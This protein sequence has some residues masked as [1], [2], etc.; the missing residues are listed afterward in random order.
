[1]VTKKGC[2]AAAL[3]AA[4]LMAA[5]GSALAEG[6]V[7][8][9]SLT[10]PASTDTRVSVP[11]TQEAVGT[12]QLAANGSG[13]TVSLTGA[14][15]APGTEFPANSAGNPLFYARFTSGALAGRWFNIVSNGAGT[16]DLNVEDTAEAANV[17]AALAGDSLEIYP[18]WTVSALFPADF[19]GLAFTV[20]TSP[21][22]RSFEV[23]L[24]RDS[25]GVGTDV[26]AGTGLFYFGTPFNTWLNFGFTPAPDTV[27]APQ[28]TL[29]LR[30]NNPVSTG[31]PDDPG[32]LIDES[33]GDLTFIGLG[34]RG[35]FEVIENIPVLSTKNDT[36]L[37]LNNITAVT[38]DESGLDAVIGNL[39]SPTSRDELLVS[40]PP[41]A[42]AGPDVPFL[43]QFVRFN[44]NWF[45]SN[46]QPA[47]DFE[48]APGSVVV[49]RKLAGTPGSS[50]DLKTKD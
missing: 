34:S 35:G 30:N 36:T 24:P 29:I 13:N 17:S 11:V 4:S 48:I 5:S 27:V 18:H 8:I 49:V 41:V 38:L 20:S 19:L 9:T 7:A 21:S 16:I 1:M 37:G 42:G 32:T 26:P 6:S 3:S 23:L 45:T 43:Q 14:A 46:L 39:V 50:V 31:L 25:D 28:A 22:A 2:I 47:G 12:F 40:S 10:V 33:S 15:F 44:G